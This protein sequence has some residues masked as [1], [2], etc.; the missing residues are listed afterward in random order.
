MTG[1]GPDSRKRDGGK[2]RCVFWRGLGDSRDSQRWPT[3]RLWPADEFPLPYELNWLPPLR[4]R[5]F[6]C[7]WISSFCC[8]TGRSSQVWP[9]GGWSRQLAAPSDGAWLCR[10]LLPLH[11][12]PVSASLIPPRGGPCR[13]LTLQPTLPWARVAKGKWMLV[14]PPQRPTTAAPRKYLPDAGRD[15]AG[16]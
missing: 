9:A 11:P 10:A 15:C 2:E 8:S 5:D 13:W 14:G 7:N 1:R 12:F 3:G 6:T 4:N 16:F